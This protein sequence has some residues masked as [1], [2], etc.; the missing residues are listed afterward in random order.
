MGCW[1]EEGD[2]DIAVLRLEEI[3]IFRDSSLFDACARMACIRCLFLRVL[4]LEHT[5]TFC[6]YCFFFLFLI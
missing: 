6:K 5:N 1:L 2:V 3:S 4:S